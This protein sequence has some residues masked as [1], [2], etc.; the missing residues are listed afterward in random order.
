MNSE[1]LISAISLTISILI[2]I[3]SYIFIPFFKHK[4]NFN[5][6]VLKF[7]IKENEYLNDKFNVNI[8]GP[9][10][11]YIY[12]FFKK[13]QVFC[14]KAVTTNNHIEIEAINI[15]FIKIYFRVKKNLLWAIKK[16]MDIKFN[17]FEDFNIYK[18]IGFENSTEEEN[19]AFLKLS[20]DE[21][22][23]FFDKILFINLD[24]EKVYLSSNL[25]KFRKN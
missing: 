8:Y 7:L 21:K 19:V 5:N 20:L 10:S 13:F 16:N 22:K 14:N 2:V 11:V 12:G 4:R 15:I 6:R 9:Y 23:Y 1:V 24:N 17:V 3:I 25:K 18:A